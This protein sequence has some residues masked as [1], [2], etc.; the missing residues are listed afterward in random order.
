M[1]MNLTRKTFNTV[2]EFLEHLYDFTCKAQTY[3]PTD[4]NAVERDGRMIIP[5]GTIWPANDA[6]AEGIVWW[7]YD[8]TDGDVVGSL[9]REAWIRT[10][11]LPEEPTAAAINAYNMK[12]VQFVPEPP[13]V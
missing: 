1:A 3:T 12:Q 10:E 5:A 6:T 9:I 13:L 11:W 7:D 8:V 2:P 4:P